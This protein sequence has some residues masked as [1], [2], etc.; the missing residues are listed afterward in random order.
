MYAQERIPALP[1]VILKLLIDTNDMATRIE[2]QQTIR[3]NL[4]KV[5]TTTGSKHQLILVLPQKVG[6][7]DHA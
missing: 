5:T 7:T 6:I 3:R 2:C 1:V 4:K